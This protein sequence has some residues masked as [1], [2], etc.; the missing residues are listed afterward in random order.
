MSGSGYVR[1]FD[2]DNASDV[3]SF[4]NFDATARA[5]IADDATLYVGGG[6]FGTGG[7]PDR[8]RR[9]TYD[10][11]STFTFDT[12]WLPVDTNSGIFEDHVRA[13]EHRAHSTR[14]C[15]WQRG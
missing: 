15:R 5:L 8:L 6:P 11:S 1:A 12:A 7:L 14:Q 10:G 4:T 2:E 13:Q 9:Y 3:V